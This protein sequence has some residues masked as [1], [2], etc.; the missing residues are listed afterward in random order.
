LTRA[1]TR[2]AAEVEDRGTGK[3]CKYACATFLAIFRSNAITGENPVATF[4]I[5][6]L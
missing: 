5:L 3:H 2:S 1:R 4:L 6:Q